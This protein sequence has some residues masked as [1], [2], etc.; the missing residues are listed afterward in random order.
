MDCERIMNTRV[1]GPK[2]PGAIDVVTFDFTKVM[3][4]ETI[5]NVVAVNVELKDGVDATPATLLNGAASIV[6]AKVLQGV[7]AGVNG[8]NYYMTCQITTSGG[9]TPVCGGVLTVR[10]DGL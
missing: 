8:A 7:K 5:A 2:H 6:G 9:R 10:R 1:L 3:R 4:G